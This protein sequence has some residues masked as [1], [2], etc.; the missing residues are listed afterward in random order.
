VIVVVP[1]ATLVTTPVA[2]F[3]VATPGTLLLHDPPLLPLALKLS[4]DPTQTDDPPLMDPAFSTGFTAINAEAVAVPH[5][6]V[7]VYVIVALP[8]PTPVTTPLAAFTVATAALLLLHEPPP[9]PLLLNG[10]DKPAHNDAAP[11]TVPAFGTGFTVMVTEVEVVAQA[12]TTVYVI[13][14]VPEP[15]PNTTPLASAIAAAGLLLLQ[16]PP[17]VPLLIKVMVEPVHTEEGPL[18]V[19]ALAAGLT[20]TLYVVNDDPQVFETE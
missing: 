7:T 11:L 19:P 17:G 12:D 20:V 16:E 13:V 6:V 15:I 8:D 5:T 14:V 2:V 1:G 10:V 18:I 3:T 4:V 9:L